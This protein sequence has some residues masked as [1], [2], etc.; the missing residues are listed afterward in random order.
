M[1]A[2]MLRE[3]NKCEKALKRYA[4]A[5]GQRY[6]TLVPSPHKIFIR[7]AAVSGDRN[8]NLYCDVDKLIGYCTTSANDLLVKSIDKDLLVKLAKYY[9]S[10]HPPVIPVL[11]KEAD[12]FEIQELTGCEQII[13]PAISMAPVDGFIWLSMKDVVIP[14]VPK[15]VNE[16]NW[17]QLSLATNVMLGFTHLHYNDVSSLKPGDVIIIEVPVNKVIIGNRFELKCRF[18]EDFMVVE[19]MDEYSEQ[20]VNEDVSFIE[21]NNF[22]VENLE[23]KVMFCIEEKTMTLAQLHNMS[24][25]E[26]IT[27]QKDKPEIIVELRVGKKIIASGELV[28]MDDRLAVEIHHI[29]GAA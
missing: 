10:Q 28:K 21:E 15:K 27:L 14:D 22:S 29:N 5:I 26:C 11:Q 6:L 8:F 18:E 13:L 16:Y 25:N 24:I 20:L 17:S 9:F 3:V 4:N 23:I 2:L 12:Q 7:I 19:S 1:S